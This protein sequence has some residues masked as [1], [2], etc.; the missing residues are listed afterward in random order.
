MRNLA[1]EQ[2]R[3]RF[4]RAAETYDA[5]AL[6]QKEL[7]ARLLALLPADRKGEILE[8]GCGTGQFTALLARLY[9]GARISALDFAE[10]MI[11]RAEKRLDGFAEVKFL[12]ADGEEFLATCAGQF[13]LICSNATLQWFADPGTALLRI[14]RLLADGGFF[15]GTFFG[16]ATFTELTHGLDAVFGRE[17]RLP[18]RDFPAQQDL[19][20][21]L[22]AAFSA[23][24]L[25]EELLTRNYPSLTGLLAHIRKTGTGGGH[26][27]G[28]LT[29]ER[30]HRLDT[31]F[32]E[33]H[34]AYPATCQTFI[35]TGEK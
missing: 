2:I 10:G 28:L 25:R 32:R 29:K 17:V 30:L 26:L 33:E 7:A 16:P 23:F 3:R 6:I 8:I 24:S 22:A 5:H 14:S 21:M 1:K 13:D 31:W 9:P 15:A 12:C 35:V 11:R 27:P 20:G 18:A 19:H 34:G 4:S